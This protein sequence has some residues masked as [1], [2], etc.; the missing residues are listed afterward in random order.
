MITTT[1]RK[2]L[3]FP[4]LKAHSRTVSLGTTGHK[5]FRKERTL[6]AQASPQVRRLQLPRD[7]GLG[8]LAS[9]EASSLGP[10]QLDFPIPHP[11]HSYA[12]S[13]GVAPAESP[14]PGSR[15]SRG[16]GEP[17]P[18]ATS[19]LSSVGTAPPRLR[20]RASVALFTA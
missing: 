9:P 5:Y 10:P 4:F 16:L 8:F 13:A 11:T 1:L 14:A 7:P 15:R 3:A 18:H 2:Q 20:T 19:H 6:G 12:P 17:E